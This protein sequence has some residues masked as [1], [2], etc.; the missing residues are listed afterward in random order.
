MLSKDRFLFVLSN[1]NQQLDC[2][3]FVSVFMN[4]VLLY[5]QKLS[6]IIAAFVSR[7]P[8]TNIPIFIIF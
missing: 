5:S 2:S 4:I 1:N 7:W 6:L 3:Q 8:T